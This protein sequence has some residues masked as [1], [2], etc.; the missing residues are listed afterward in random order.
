VANWLEELARN[1]KTFKLAGYSNLP[2]EKTDYNVSNYLHS[3][4]KH[5]KVLVTQYKSFVGFKTLLTAGLLIIG[6]ALVVNRE[7][8]IGQFVA[9]EIIIIM[10]ISAIEKLILSLE[11]IYDVLASVDKLGVVTDLPIEKMKGVYLSDIATEEGLSMEVKDLSY[12]FP[13]SDAFSLQDISFQLKNGEILC[14]GGFNGSG[15]T[16]LVN[17]LLGF[18]ASYKGIIKYNGVSMKDLNKNSLLNSIGDNINY[19]NIFDGTIEENITLGRKDIP[20]KSLYWAMESIGLSDYINKMN[21]GL[22]TKLVAGNK[23]LPTHIAKK[24]I[25]ARSIIKKPKLLIL[26]E[27]LLNNID[28]KE[29][30]RILDFLMNPGFKWTVI[31]LSNKPRIMELCNNVIVLKEGKIAV[32]GPFETIKDNKDVI[33]LITN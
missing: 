27:I 13:E 12:K 33:D 24:I 6:A 10:I 8:N 11:V 2:I 28:N 5:F 19:E 1:L 9:S 25:L 29:R 4:E 14:I 16:T 30:Q 31:I 20:T 17:T 26:D 3:R 32:Q 23:S 22:Q 18:Y 7:I 15:R 21:E